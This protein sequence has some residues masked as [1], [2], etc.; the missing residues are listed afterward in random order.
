MFWIRLVKVLYLQLRLTETVRRITVRET[1]K[2]KVDDSS[3]QIYSHSERPDL[4]GQKWSSREN[5]PEFLY[6]AEGPSE[7][8]QQLIGEFPEF[9]LYCCDEAGTL[10][11]IAQSIPIFWDGTEAGLPEGWTHVLE[12]GLKGDLAPTALAAIRV[13]IRRDCQRRGYSKQALRA[14]RQLAHRHDLSHL[15]APVR[16]SLKSQYPL[17]PMERYVKWVG[18]GGEPFDPWIRVH[19]REGG[20][21]LHIAPRSVT[22]RATVSDWEEWTDMQFPETGEYVVPGALAPVSIDREENIGTHEEPGVWFVHE[23]LG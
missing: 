23:A 1:M 21:Q 2:P 17:A 20:R 10:V 9:Q 15:I 18:R 13:D 19:V 7:V 4:E 14:M 8:A 22:F 5:L 16:P 11:G 12:I 6:H 3:L